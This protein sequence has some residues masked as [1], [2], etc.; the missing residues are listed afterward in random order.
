MTLRL[1]QTFL[2]L[3]FSV[4]FI[5]SA[6]ELDKLLLQAETHYTEKQTFQAI[7]TYEEILIILA[8]SEDKL[9][10]GQVHQ[11]L[12]EL[13]FKATDYQKSIEHLSPSLDYLEDNRARALCL[14]YAAWSYERLGQLDLAIKTYEESLEELSDLNNRVEELI[15]KSGLFWPLYSQ[16]E[17]ENAIKTVKKSLA[18]AEKEHYYAEASSLY[19]CLSYSSNSNKDKIKFAENSLLYAE[20]SENGYHI[21]RSHY[22]L[23]Q[24]QQSL[25]KS[26]QAKKT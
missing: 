19:I 17:T 8:S 26:K 7:N 18:I 24:I 12:N 14:C 10:L 11:R 21:G 23:G 16:G 6:A 5:V 1:L 13:Y 3:S 15:I 2:C 22:W 20:R 9:L 25:S 4:Q